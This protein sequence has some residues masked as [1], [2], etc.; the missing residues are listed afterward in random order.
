MKS[1]KISL[2]L[3]DISRGDRRGL[4]EYSKDFESKPEGIHYDWTKE[5]PGISDK[6]LWI[7]VINSIKIRLS[8]CITSTHL[9]N[10]WR[11]N[12]TTRIL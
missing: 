12:S 7:E 3:A 8:H 9:K 5:K 1:G 2:Y 4:R 6:K 11:Y 10:I